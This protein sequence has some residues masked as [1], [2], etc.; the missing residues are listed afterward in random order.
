M[1]VSQPPGPV[2]GDSGHI[3]GPF[4]AGPLWASSLF[5]RAEAHRGRETGTPGPKHV[6]WGPKTHLGGYG[7]PTGV[8]VD[9]AILGPPV[10]LW[11]LLLP[12]ATCWLGAQAHP[13]GLVTNPKPAEVTLYLQRCD[14]DPNPN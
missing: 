8:F 7:T 10:T 6:V 14:P 1:L 12:V 2:F 4:W 11:C 3:Y 5:G 9:R 13:I